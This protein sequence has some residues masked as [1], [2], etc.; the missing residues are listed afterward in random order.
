VV[1]DVSDLPVGELGTFDFFLDIG[2]FQHLD[3]D[4]RF[5]AGLR[6]PPGTS[7]RPPTPKS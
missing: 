3:A 4:Q 1:G 5:A 2:C 7:W 6:S